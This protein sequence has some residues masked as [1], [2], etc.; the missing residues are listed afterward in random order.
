MLENKGLHVRL[1]I[2]TN[3]HDLLNACPK[4]GS[5]S[6]S[7]HWSVCGAVGRRNRSR[8]TTSC[9][10]RN[11]PGSLNSVYSSITNSAFQLFLQALSA[12]A[13][14]LTNEE[15]VSRAIFSDILLSCQKS[16]STVSASFFKTIV[17]K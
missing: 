3:Y 8:G 6:C 11:L 14:L 2:Q 17:S 9:C 12:H 10:N 7:A 16:S 15:Y 13:A 5:E 1:I 4:L